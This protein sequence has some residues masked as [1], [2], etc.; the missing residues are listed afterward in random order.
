MIVIL[1]YLQ[2]YQYN[3]DDL[4]V[5]IKVEEQLYVRNPDS[6]KLGQKII[7]TSIEMINQLGFEKFT[8][9]KLSTQIQST[10][11]SVYRYFENKHQL[12][13]YLTSW[14]WNWMFYKIYMAT[15]NIDS[16]IIKL[17]NAIDILTKDTKEDEA[18]LYVN[19]ILLNK[20][21]ITES[22]KAIHTKNVDKENENG[23][24]ESY[25]KV[26]NKVADLILKINPNFK[27]AHMLV[28]T[29]IEGAQQQQYYIN[30]LPSLTDNAKVEDTIATFYNEM[31]FKTIKK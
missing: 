13:L 23:C 4:G 8:F 1:L 30:H 9:K 22:S 20:I 21:I 25:K 5:L 6:S 3:M 15:V 27:Y 19:E 11:S 26:I 29:V 17:K 7:T 2:K 14:Y 18:I 16:S 31:V 10:E 28:T 24:F 12:L